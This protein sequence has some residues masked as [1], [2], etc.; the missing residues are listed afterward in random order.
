[1]SV[2]ED[3]LEVRGKDRI[4]AVESLFGKI[5]REPTKKRRKK[6]RNNAEGT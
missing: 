5:N 2:N 3:A 6:R 1:M 4:A